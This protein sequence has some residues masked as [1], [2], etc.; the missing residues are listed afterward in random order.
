MNP[1]QNETLLPFFNNSS[2]IRN[3]GMNA[4]NMRNGS[5]CGYQ[6]KVN[7]RPLTRLNR[8]SLYHFMELESLG[9]GDYQFD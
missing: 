9:L 4:K 3:S 6:E 2:L 7:S 1:F 5:P 8:M